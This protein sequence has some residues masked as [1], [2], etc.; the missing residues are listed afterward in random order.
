MDNASLPHGHAVIAALLAAAF[1]AWSPGGT[2]E[3]ACAP[4]AQAQPAGAA[5]ADDEVVDFLFA[6]PS[7][8]RHQALEARL[9][10]AKH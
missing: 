1:V 3:H 8:W 7:V 2:T 9:A 6:P 5:T 10:D 4:L